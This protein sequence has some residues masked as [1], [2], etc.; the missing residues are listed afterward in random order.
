MTRRPSPGHLKYLSARA[1]SAE[2]F[3]RIAVAQRLGATVINRR[4][5]TWQ[6]RVAELEAALAR[7]KE[8]A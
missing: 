2:R 7:A 4:R 3:Y 5:R 1:E 8:A 6:I